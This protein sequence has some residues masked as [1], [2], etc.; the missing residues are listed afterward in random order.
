M[1]ERMRRGEREWC[2]HELAGAAREVE[3]G[4]MPGGDEGVRHARSF[5][6]RWGATGESGDCAADA[7]ESGAREAPFFLHGWKSEAMF[8][9]KMGQ[10]FG[11]ASDLL[12]E[13]NLL[14]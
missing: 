6:L 8:H 1:P 10:R 11:E 9:E 4:A 5:G 12:S 14:T 13:Y 7:G 2:R 3:R